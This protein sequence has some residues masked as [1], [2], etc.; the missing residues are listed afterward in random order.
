MTRALV[1]VA[2]GSSLLAAAALAGAA[3][4]AATNSS[5]GASTASTAP[6]TVL[7][8]D[9][10]GY[11]LSET[12]RAY[13]LTAHDLAGRA[14]VVRDDGGRAVYRGTIA[15][16]DDRG[17]WSPSYGHVFELDF[18]RLTQGGSYTV[19]LDDGVDTVASVPFAIATAATLFTPVLDSVAT[20]F[21]SQ[22]DGRDVIAGNLDRR[23][24]HLDDVDATVYE[25]AGLFP[26]PDS[27]VPGELIPR[28]NANGAELRRDVEGGWFDAGDY[29]K[30]V[31]TTSY[32]VTMLA[33]A[34][35]RAGRT[36]VVSGEI[37]HGLTWLDKM[38][39]DDE[40]VL[41]HQVGLGTGNGEFTGDHDEWRLPEADD[42]LD[43]PRDAVPGSEGAASYFLKYRPVFA[44]NTAGEPLSPNLAGRVAA[45][46]A[47]A[48]QRDSDAGLHESAAGWFEKAKHVYELADSDWPVE[49]RPLVT[50]EPRSYYPEDSYLDD[51]ALGGAEL[52]RAAILLGDLDLAAELVVEAAGYAAA[53]EGSLLNLYDT[54]ALANAELVT[55]IRALESAGRP[56]EGGAEIEAE[57]LAQLEASGLAAAESFARSD[58]FSAVSDP[59]EWDVV[60]HT[61]G[62]I[63]VVR[64]AEQLTGDRS[65]AD[66]ASGARNWALG[67]NAWGLSFV[68]GTGADF[69]QCPHHQ[70]GNLLAR[71]E[72][73]LTLEGAVV[74]GPNGSEWTD[75]ADPEWWNPGFVD[76]CPAG[77]VDRLA[78][79]H[80]PA[81]DG[82]RGPSDGYRG[83]RFLDWS[84]VWS[85]SEPAIDF[86][87]SALLALS[88][89]ATADASAPSENVAS[90][91]DDAA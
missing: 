89:E 36:P 83:T 74:N 32:A 22:R 64:L 77:R 87:A 20:F 78:A 41:Y 85:T 84:G 28:L 91:V 39:D 7:R 34:E 3:W 69:P 4:A 42:A 57:L 60:S 2:A 67:A 45:S 43:I 18:S 11:S 70:I 19:E 46:F 48:A 51:L 37:A 33:I 35:Q 13:A 17:R 79:F 80:S 56:V 50:T 66:V 58:P 16:G 9:Q 6:K 65:Y 44:A 30:F 82:E 27:E 31:Q 40:R 71:P 81:A 26:D 54:S 38:W 90:R 23:P 24:S 12:K 14:F 62:S 75:P 21:S 8:V 76:D 5:A 59:A 49:E 72:A 73:G 55:A 53:A 88:L 25:T 52:A 61:F 1:A 86:T 10:V 63:A 47:L 29:L 68:I 15:A